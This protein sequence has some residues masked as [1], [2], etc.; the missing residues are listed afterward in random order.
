M[1]RVWGGGLSAWQTISKSENW[2]SFIK[3]LKIHI[4]HWLRK[5]LKS[6]VSVLNSSVYVNNKLNVGY[7]KRQSFYKLCST[8]YNW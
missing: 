7:K 2:L 4:V 5:G 8:I 3:K 6:L 1:P